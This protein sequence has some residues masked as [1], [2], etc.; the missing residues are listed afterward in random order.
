MAREAWQRLPSIH[1]LPG[2]SFVPFLFDKMFKPEKHTL[3]KS[4][5]SIRKKGRWDLHIDFY[6]LPEPDQNKTKNF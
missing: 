5:K 3:H 6:S 2:H 4:T 1:P